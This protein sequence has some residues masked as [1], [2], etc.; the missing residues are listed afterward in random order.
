M[1]IKRI[2]LAQSAEKDALALELIEKFPGKELISVSGV[3]EANHYL[4]NFSDPLGEGKQSIFLDYFKG[5]FLEPCPCTKAYVRCGY[6]IISPVVGCPL[7]CSYCV[8]QDY[9]TAYPIQVYLNLEKIFEEVER[10]EKEHPKACLRVGTGELADSL[11]LEPE[12]GYAKKLI[13]FFS[14]KKNFI[15][16]LKTKTERISPIVELSPRENIVVSWSLNPEEIINLEEKGSA[17]LS[18]RLKSAKII[19]EQGWLVAFHLD[20]ILVEAGKSAYLDLVDKIFQA[21]SAD[22]IAWISLGS[23]RFP[24][25]LKSIIQARHPESKILCGELFPGKDAKL[26][27]LRP[28]REKFYREIFKRIR[29]HSDKILVYLCMESEELWKKNLA[30]SIELVRKK[31]ALPISE[32]AQLTLG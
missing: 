18:A 21:V 31:L 5:R 19:S 15:F 6:W 26:R 14:E 23:L 24:Q 11:A 25:S 7:D 13:E 12:L 29:E 1:R 20:P 27:Y 3:I 22:K 30:D 28:V 16:E 9:L 17:S 8:L 4:K 10:F 32:R 2:F